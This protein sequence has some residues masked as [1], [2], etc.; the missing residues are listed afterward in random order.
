MKGFEDPFVSVK[1]TVKIIKTH[2]LIPKDVSIYGF[3]MD[4]VTG[5]LDAVE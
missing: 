4:P 3:I 5:R 2:P 1:E